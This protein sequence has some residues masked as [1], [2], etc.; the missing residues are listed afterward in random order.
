MTNTV[1]TMPVV[2]FNGVAFSKMVITPSAR[3]HWGERAEEIFGYIYSVLDGMILEADSIE[4]DGTP[5]YQVAS[6]TTN[7]EG[8]WMIRPHR[9]TCFRLYA[10]AGTIEF[11]HGSPREESWYN[12]WLEKS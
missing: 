6:C 4:R 3:K 2:M 5:C 10:S 9:D 8:P 11:F 7:I 12:K 1:L